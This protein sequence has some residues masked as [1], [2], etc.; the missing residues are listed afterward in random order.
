MTNLLVIEDETNIRLLITSNLSARGFIVSEAETGEHGLTLLRE[1]G[2][3]A[4]I[5]DIFLP[6]MT[7]WD[8]LERMNQDTVLKEIPVIVLTA[9]VSAELDQSSK[10]PNVVEHLT[11]PTGIGPLMDAVRKALNGRNASS[12]S[13]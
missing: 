12:E 13:F 2:P 10:Y 4:L 8:V 9:S 6:D 3:A 7:G 11:K 1:V 5:L